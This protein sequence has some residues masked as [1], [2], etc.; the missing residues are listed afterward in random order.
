[1]RVP[2]R[3]FAALYLGLIPTYAFVYACLPYH[4]YH[5]TVRYEES[6]RSDANY[7]AESL[8][9][10]IVE[11]FE[12]HYGGGKAT[13][14]G[15]EVESSTIRVSNVAAHRNYLD[16]TL[17]Y[18]EQRELQ[19]EPVTEIRVGQIKLT[20]TPRA[21]G[22]RQKAGEQ[23]QAVT[24]DDNGEYLYPDPK[25]SLPDICPPPT[26]VDYS[27]VVAKNSNLPMAVVVIPAE[28]LSL[29]NGYI[30]ADTGFPSFI[31][32]NFE[33]MLYLSAMTITTV[34]FGDIVP[35]T[36]LARTLV[37]SEAVVGVVLAGLFINAVARRRN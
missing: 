32:G 34:G 26:S 25:T 29:I 30:A 7:I 22:K 16:F 2:A 1:M 15:T 31:T 27:V 33:R 17:N 11:N 23:G 21:I 19:G 28:T 36:P 24:I 13:I 8:R 6:F 5:S 18:D 20:L 9:R 10:S 4:F 35:I 14:R 12:K 37:A 3:A